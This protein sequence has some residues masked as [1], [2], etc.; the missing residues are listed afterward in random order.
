M[1]EEEEEDEEAVDRVP[2]SSEPVGDGVDDGGGGSAVAPA[3][4]PA[5]I[6]PLEAATA[7]PSRNLLYSKEFFVAARCRARSDLAIASAMPEVTPPPPPP[8]PPAPAPQQTQVYSIDAATTIYLM[9]ASLTCDQVSDRL[10]CLAPDAHRIF[11]S[12]KTILPRD[13]LEWDASASASVPLRPPKK[14]V[15]LSGVRI[16]LGVKIAASCLD[17]WLGTGWGR[18]VYDR[19][20]PHKCR[21]GPNCLQHR[22]VTFI[23]TIVLRASPIGDG[24]RWSKNAAAGAAVKR[25]AAASTSPS[26]LFELSISGTIR[27][28]GCTSTESLAAATEREVMAILNRQ[29]PKAQPKPLQQAAVLDDRA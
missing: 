1:F 4:V 26:V 20:K 27:V 21:R 18:R 8:P 17:E 19:H 13:M 29:R 9:S 6:E 16:A 2:G 22:T 25:V 23:P 11:H 5:P 12:V 10:P 3:V 15:L 28:H 14:L 7:V 24:R